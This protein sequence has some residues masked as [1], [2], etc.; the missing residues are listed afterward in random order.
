MET[1]NH[2][3]VFIS[4]RNLDKIFVDLL[5]VFLMTIG[6]PTNS[7]FCSSLPGNDVKCEISKEIKLAL[8]ASKVNIVMLSDAYYKSPY[9]QQEAGVIWFCETKKIVLALP[10]INVDLMEGF[11]DNE[12]RIRRLDCKEDILTIVDILKEASLTITAPVAQIHYRAD[13]LIA[14]YNKA[15][16]DRKTPIISGTS[17]VENE[18]ENEI[19]SN[20]L[21]DDELLVLSYFY[22]SQKNKIEASQLDIVS[23][24]NSATIKNVDITN[25][26]T[27]LIEDNKI[28]TVYDE[29]GNLLSY[30]LDIKFYRLLRRLSESAVNVLMTCMNNYASK[31][32]KG[33][34]NEIDNL[35]EKGFTKEEKIMIQYIID[36]DRDC[37]F[38]GWQSDKEEKMIRNW[39]GINELDHVLSSKYDDVL[40][41]FS[42][43]KFIEVKEVTSYGNPKEYS[44]N[45]Y[46]KK[47][48]NTINSNSKR[49][50]KE[51]L[52]EC[53]GIFN[54]CF[55]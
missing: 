55:S 20:S 31:D 50:I 38:A 51:T 48:I 52:D 5:T 32:N 30:S 42:I 11:L 28:N 26:I 22:Q 10:E 35:I 41:K 47:G 53:K 12:H 46:F 23:W 3:D 27:L 45:A 40:N 4:H 34:Q 14:E 33:S 15:L 18:L 29:F 25:G 8:N 43:R 1:K 54:S 9:C 19:L 39:E 7:I 17:N 2:I 6:I 21:S 44:L 37:L 36:L 16:S 49:V 24:L 13:S